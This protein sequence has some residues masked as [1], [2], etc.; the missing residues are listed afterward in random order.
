MLNS[1]GFTA[2]AGLIRVGISKLKAASDHGIAVVENKTIEIQH[3]FAIADDLE[4]VVIKHLVIGA[5]VAALFKV[6]HVGHSR[7][8]SLANAHPQAEILP[9]LSAQQDNMLKGSFS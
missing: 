3:T 5:H 7:T 9:L 4:A 2:A 8:S 1:E 6:H